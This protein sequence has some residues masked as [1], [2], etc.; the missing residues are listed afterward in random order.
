MQSENEILIM[1]SVGIL[2]MALMVMAVVVFV[3]L[4][5]QRGIKNRLEIAQIKSKQQEELIQSITSA[6]EIERKRISSQLHD[7][8]GAAL[9]SVNL[10]VGRIRMESQGSTKEMAVDAGE[11]INQVMTEVRNIVQ[12]MS[13]SL[14]EKFGLVESIN[15]ICRKLNSSGLLNASFTNNLS[16]DITNKRVELLIYRI[17]QELTNNVIKHAQC[18]NIIIRFETQLDNLAI[19]VQDDGLGID[20]ETAFTKKSLGLVNIKNQIEILGGSFNIVNQAIGGTVA[21]IQIPK[22]KLMTKD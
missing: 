20:L 17:V 11:Q 9:S 10:L 19:T 1:I 12:N 2:A 13:P 16:I 22:N 21:M 14:V 5:H 15:E 8:V 18:K 4:Y 7:E 3:A 6:Q